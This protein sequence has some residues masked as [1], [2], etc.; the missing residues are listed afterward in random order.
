MAV[1]KV[2]LLQLAPRE[3]MDE[4][5]H[6]GLSACRE[7]AANGADIALFPE[8]WSHGYDF[9]DLEDPGVREAWLAGAVFRSD[10]FVCE[11]QA[12]A[13]DA[14]LAM[15]LTTL[16]AY[17]G[18]PR[19]AFCLID[20]A[21]AI[22]LDYAKVHTCGHTMERFCAAGDGFSVVSLATAKGPV[23]VGAMICFDREFPESARILAL[24]GA[25]LVLVPNCCNIEAHRIA[26]MKTR[27]FENK[28]A[29]AM[30]NY[31]AGHPE[32]NGRS[33]AVVPMAFAAGGEDNGQ[34]HLSRDVDPRGRAGG[35][36]LL[37][38]FRPRRDPRLSPQR[39]LGR[40]LPPARRLRRACRHGAR[41]RLPA[42]PHRALGLPA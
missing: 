26:Q 8:V 24:Q 9:G 1:L 5:L 34:G 7:A 39:D 17:P 20:A 38:R 36:R 32:A 22:V 35:G 40:Q 18:A 4:T 21:G 6:K 3:T 28:I 25:E 15:G 2:A 14:G 33:L 42:G 37:L 31:P 27:A 30:T 29:V 16:E 11:H 12:L 19:N 10:A 41:R 23:D 13:R